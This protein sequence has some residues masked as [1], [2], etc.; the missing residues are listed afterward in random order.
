[1]AFMLAAVGLSLATIL[2]KTD[3]IGEP[4]LASQTAVTT[5]NL[6]VAFIGDQGTRAEAKAVLQLII[7]ESADMVLHQGDLGYG[8]E[9]DPQSAIDWDNQITSMLGP[10]FPYFASI[11]NHDVGQWAI[12]QQK[13]QERLVRIP[14]ASCTGNLGVQAA[15]SYA[16]LFFLL[17]GPGTLGTGHDVYIRDQLAADDSLWSVCSWHR[18]QRKMQVGGKGDE[19]GWGVYE[20]CRIGGGIVA[21]AHSHTYSRTH[22]IDDFDAPGGPN[23]VST[24]SVFTIKKGETFG[25]VSGIGGQNIRAQVQPSDAWWASIYSSTQGAT[26]GALFCTFNVN[27]QADRADCYF[28][29]IAGNVQD[30]FTV[31]SAVEPIPLLSASI[32]Q[33]D[34]VA[35][36]TT[37]AITIDALPNGLS[38][39]NI[40]VSLA[41]PSIGEITGVQY[42]AAL[43]LTSAAVNLP[44]SQVSLLAVDINQNIQSGAANVGLATL[45]IGAL[46]KGTTSVDITLGVLGIDDGNGEDINPLTIQSGSFTVNNIVPAVDAGNGATLTEGDT[47]SYA[48]SFNDPDNS[49]LDWTAT[50]DYDDGLGTRSLTLTGQ[51]FNLGHTY[52]D[53]GSFAVNVSVDDGDGGVGVAGMSITR[54]LS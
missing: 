36:T 32:A 34:L 2:G 51:S 37:V 4:I 53:E 27:G 9:A 12:Y 52:G 25:F 17:V 19:T 1:M 48:G 29:D 47:F 28:K 50:V 30:Q 7:D 20:E 26:F 41:D 45:T 43:G 11:G 10:N 46:S 16:G 5:P 8:N 23:I 21:T 42:D 22:L 14:G 31:F 49:G 40:D 15:C 18:V 13:L 54:V 35:T 44:D 38:G 33:A 24:S 39:L 6:T 3:D